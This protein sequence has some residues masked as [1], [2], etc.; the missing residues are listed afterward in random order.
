MQEWE[1][2]T[3]LNLTI[4]TMTPKEKAQDLFLKCPIVELGD[5]KGI[6]KNDLSIEALKQVL[7]FFV[8]EIIKLSN[9]IE[10][11]YWNEVKKEIQQL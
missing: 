1:Y 10:I 6:V 2:L 7:L 8:D 4:K 11:Y 9:H 3:L 5:A